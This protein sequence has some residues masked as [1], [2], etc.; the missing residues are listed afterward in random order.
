[1]T[2]DNEKMLFEYHIPTQHMLPVENITG[3]M[4]VLSNNG[5]SIKWSWDFDV[6]DE[7][8]AAAKEA[9]SQIGGMGIQGIQDLVNQS[10]TA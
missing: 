5:V 6:E 4:Q 8:E 3:A 9:L 2:L 1:M 10:A 7:N